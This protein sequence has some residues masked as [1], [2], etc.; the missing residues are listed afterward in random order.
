MPALIVDERGISKDIDGIIR[1]DGIIVFRVIERDGK[2]FIQAKDYD[3]KRIKCR[4]SYFVEVPIEIFI[5]R[6]TGQEIP[7]INP[8]PDIPV[9]IEV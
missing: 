7:S 6:I 4:H 9:D 5:A 3:R 1:V 2:K 8:E